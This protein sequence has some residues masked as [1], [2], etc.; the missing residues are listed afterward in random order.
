MRGGVFRM[1]RRRQKWPPAQL[2]DGRRVVIVI[3]GDGTETVNSDSRW[4]DG[5]HRA[6]E[7]IVVLREQARDQRVS[8]DYVDHRC[9]PRRLEQSKAVLF[10]DLAG[11]PVVLPDHIRRPE[12]RNRRLLIGPR[13]AC[14]LAVLL[15]LIESLN[16]LATLKRRRG[17]RYELVSAL[18][19]EG[20]HV[21][22]PRNLGS[23]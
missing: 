7:Q 5:S 22:H 13:A 19:D 10:G 11:E 3:P 6:P 14:Q 20:L 17:I 15:D 21:S 12:L 23:S 8:A 2:L 4:V 9:Q 18:Q 16:P 1:V